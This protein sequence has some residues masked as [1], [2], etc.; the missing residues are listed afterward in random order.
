[1]RWPPKARLPALLLAP[2]LAL[3]LLLRL[4]GPGPGPAPPASPRR[5]GPT[6]VLLLSSWRSG[7]SFVGQLFS[8]HPDVF[9]LMEPAWHVWMALPAGSAAQL[10][11][12]ARDLLRS[13]FLCDLAVFEAYLAP[14]PRDQSSLFQWHVSRAL[15]SPPACPLFERGTIVPQEGCMK[16]CGKTPLHLAEAACRSYSHVALKEV[17]FLGLRA[18]YP[19]LADPALDLRVV[20]LVRDPRAV[21]RSRE[22]VAP[23]LLRDS[24]AVLGPQWDRV[25]REE[26]PLRVL[27]AICRSHVRI[28][29]EA[30]R[31]PGPLAARYLLVRYEDL[32]R[33]PLTHT[34]RLYDFAGLP[35]PPQLRVW[36]QN[37]TRGKGMGRS[38]FLTDSRNARNVSQAWR[39]ALPHDQVVQIQKVCKDAMELMGYLPVLSEKHQKNLLL[40]LLSAFKSPSDTLV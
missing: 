13:V 16:V 30:R 18:L 4:A 26:R 9:Y 14:G 15:C 37:I 1:M 19:L 39:W 8:Q 11:M 3:L 28:R 21:F 31:L 20:H 22:L 29:E 10:Q 38:A 36:V 2:A 24:R 32:A 27:G 17:R 7:S 5:P 33:D 6:H 35:F 12:A 25:P 40:D 23:L 34:S